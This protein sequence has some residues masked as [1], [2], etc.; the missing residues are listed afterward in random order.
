VQTPPSITTQPSNTTVVAG[1]TANFTV[2]AAGNPAVSYQWQVSTDGGFSFGNLTDN[3]NITGSATANLSIANEI[4]FRNGFLYQ[5]VVSNVA[6]AVTSNAVVLTVQFA[7]AFT[8]QPANVTVNVGDTVNFTVATTG[9]PAPT[10]QWQVSTNGGANFTNVILSGNII[11]NTSTTLTMLLTPTSANGDLFQCVA[12]N[13]VG[14]TN[15]TAAVLTVNTPPTITVQPT[16]PPHLNGLTPL[17]MSVTLAGTPPF[18]YQWMQNGMPIPGAT[19]ST[20]IVLAANATNSGNYSVLVSN[21]G[22]NVT[23]STTIPVEVD[24][25]PEVSMP[26]LSP[27]NPVKRGTAAQFHVVAYGVQPL[28]FQWEK[29]GKRM[30]NGGR[31]SGAN[32]L[33]LTIA[34]TNMTDV[35]NYSV[36]VTNSLGKT[37]SKPAAPLSIK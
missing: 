11:G 7:P 31:I 26:Q 15:S 2:V 4:A 9:N 18:S 19:S 17:A 5:C 30:V 13:S 23:S 8:T 37:T 33:Q 6:G 24:M 12:T 34:R 22:G 25:K 1:G 3:A 29:N 27:K 32:G 36:V 10:L 21:I 16:V 35:G 14:V 20:Y 28:G